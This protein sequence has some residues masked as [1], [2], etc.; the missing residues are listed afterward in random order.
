MGQT[1]FL[2]FPSDVCS[3]LLDW[4][5]HRVTPGCKGDRDAQLSPQAHSY[6]KSKAL[7]VRKDRKMDTG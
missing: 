5:Y 4:T 2:Q 3:P 7:L 1:D 6:P